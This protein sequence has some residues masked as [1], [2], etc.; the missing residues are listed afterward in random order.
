MI[1]III[2]IQ[3]IADDEHVVWLLSSFHENRVLQR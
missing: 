3:G 2:I 1:I